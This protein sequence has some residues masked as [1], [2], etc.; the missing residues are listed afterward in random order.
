MKIDEE[1]RKDLIDYAKYQMSMLTDYFRTYITELEES[2]DVDDIMLAKQGLIFNYID[3]MPIGCNSCY[4]CL[5][6][7]F[8]HSGRKSCDVCEYGKH[9][10][11]CIGDNSKY[12]K[13][14]KTIAELEKYVSDDYYHDGEFKD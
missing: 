14:I 10:G 1:I 11:I 12:I 2:S 3:G 6:R 7:E 5:I 8:H 9:H 13:F 4:F